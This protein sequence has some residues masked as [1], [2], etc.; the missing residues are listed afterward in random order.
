MRKKALIVASVASVVDQFNKENIKIL[1][2]QGFKVF[3]AA[4][5]S[6]GN[7]S[8]KIRLSSFL[9]EL[10]KIRVKVWNIPFPRKLKIIQLV[11]SYFA[12]K[13]IIQAD[14]FNIIHCHN[15][16]AS[17]ILR[18]IFIFNKK[19]QFTKIIYTAHGFHFFKG[20]PLKNWIIYFPLEKIM[21]FYTDILITINN[22]DYKRAKSSFKNIQEIKKIDGVGIDTKKFS[23]LSSKKEKIKIREKLKLDTK[24]FI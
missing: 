11:R 2:Q 13:R 6:S 8:S 3:V 17:F 15:P 19:S 7:T 1:H 23:P 12:L 20:A 22:E 24:A 9:D 14:Y 5:F 18:L 16:I 21:S 4:N 10:K